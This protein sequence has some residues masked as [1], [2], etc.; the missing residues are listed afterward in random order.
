MRRHL[1]LPLILCF[2]TISTFAQ[3]KTN[4]DPKPIAWK[5]I[6]SW[7][8][9]SP[10]SVELSPDGK[11]LAY[12]LSPVEGDG[13]L[14]LQ[15]AGDPES[16]KRYPIGSS[17][18]PSISFSD[19]GRWI[20]FKES[21]KDKEKKANEKS[22][23]KPLG[24]KLILID[25]L[26]D[27][28]TVIEKVSSFSFNGK[29]STHLAI[30]LGKEGANGDAKGSDLLMVHLASGK[31]QNIGN[32]LEFG[33]NKPGSHLAYTID[34]ENKSGNGLYLLNISTGNTQ[35]L[36]SDTATYRSLS[37]T[38]KGDAFALLK[39]VKDKKYKQDHGKVIGVKNLANPQITVYDPKKDSLDFPKEYTISPNRKPL[40]TEDL[41]RL[42][43]GVHRLELAKKEEEKKSE[44]K[45]TLALS[46]DKKIALIKGDTTIKS[47]ADLQKAI[48]KM[49]STKSKPMVSKDDPTKPDMT[50]W[51]WQDSRLQSRQQV[52]ENQDKNYSLWAL[53]DL[54]SAKNL[55]LQDSSLKDLNILP[56]HNFALGEDL[57][58]YELDINLDGQNYR[59]FYVVDLKTGERKAI[60]EKFYLPNYASYP[61]SSPDGTQ[62]LFGKDGH[63]Y[64]YDLKTGMQSNLTENIAVTFVDTEDDHNVV[65]PL[66]SPLGWS[67]DSKYV[68]LRD[69]WDIWQVPL[70]PK[71]KAIN[72]TQNGRREKIRYQS[73]FVL[74]PEE[75]GIDLSK[76]QYLRMYGE[77][78]KKSGIV[79]LEA[80]KSKLLA[81][82]KSLI[83]ED[84]NINRLSKAKSADVY[85]FSKE[86][87]TLPT[88]FYVTDAALSNPKITTEN[89]PEASKFKWS[90]GVRLIDYVTD[91]GDSLQG[92]LYLPAG[93]EEGK[94]YPTL[95]YY[96]EKLSQN[97]HSYSNPGFSGTGWNPNVYT[98]NG[99]A[100]FVPD[101]VYE[102]DDPGM[103]AVWCVLPA[104]KEAI[105]TGIIDETNIGIH[106]HSWGGYQTSFLITQTDM[107][108]AA[109]A[110]APLTNMVSMYDL[111]YW[112]SG[113][114]NM[115][116]FEA[117]QGRFKGAPWENWDSYLRNSP[118]Y[119]VKNVN[120]P[121]LMLHNDKDGAVDF[122]QGIEYYNALR[123]LKKP[124]ILIQYKGENHGLAKLE[125]RKDYSVRMMEF[126]D[127]HL[128]GAVLP[129]WMEKGIERLKLESH[130]ED[131]AF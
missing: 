64:S 89:A 46:E 7:K 10:N 1:L 78:T 69:G 9:M 116:I 123:R 4:Q 104:V 97:L 45:D 131:R 112:N 54:A 70:S 5:D 18:N 32:V 105:K 41:T 37:W 12:I 108:K 93:Y 101:I 52:L 53:Y 47:V 118:V 103:S 130:L 79:R 44:A 85:L 109:A 34:A 28:K 19:D 128:K 33:F 62:L 60:F 40:W 87:F 48:A 71:E 100:V 84:A 65:K 20:A 11:W 73:R 36:E 42:M 129:N 72:L 110:G 57:Q 38:E 81:G 92:A 86:T 25:L 6:P 63:F 126:F 59:D 30:N 94:K 15:K 22:K 29:S 98:S 35:V 80:G 31:R 26:M 50:I 114:G 56:K 39:L 66:V 125:N 111:I 67:A 16:K 68:L 102:L 58:A 8:S 27:K 49:D 14:L 91:K 96:Y 23:G 117:S 115:S 106:G 122:T 13:E 95:I 51:H 2:V 120:T 90:S 21:P 88:E 77:R 83:W 24:E 121:L 99:Y 82:T 74:D 119:H 43:Y 107:F 3:E 127:F 61:R 76:A 55:I 113:G 124:V 17:S 75:K